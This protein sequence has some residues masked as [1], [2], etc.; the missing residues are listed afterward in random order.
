MTC[1]SGT[2]AL[3]YI[4][5]S[6]YV[7]RIQIINIFLNFSNT[8]MSRYNPRAYRFDFKFGREPGGIFTRRENRVYWSAVIS[9]RMLS[10]P[11]S[12]PSS[13]GDYK[14]IAKFCRS[15]LRANFAHGI[16]QARLCNVLNY[17]AREHL[18]LRADAR[19]CASRASLMVH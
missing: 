8:L 17:C 2:S 7:I 16:T 12:L 10:F 18:L 13:T 19:R 11:P 15:I 6:H 14:R 9:A 1:F 4:H 5:I 3:I